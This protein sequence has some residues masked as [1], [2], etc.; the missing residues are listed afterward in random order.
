MERLRRFAQISY[1]GLPEDARSNSTFQPDR[2][3]EWAFGPALG[4]QGRD[5]WDTEVHKRALFYFT[6]LKTRGET[7]E[8][9]ATL[10]LSSDKPGAKSKG[11]DYRAPSPGED[12][13]RK[14]KK[15][16]SGGKKQKNVSK[17]I[18]LKAQRGT[19]SEPCPHGRR[20]VHS[21]QD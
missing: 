12:P 20:R 15:K 21:D 13:S 11:S 4:E 7:L 18:C 3:W 17:E 10:C 5:F 6:K 16:L 2:P 19:C 14:K 8:D 9:G 1:E